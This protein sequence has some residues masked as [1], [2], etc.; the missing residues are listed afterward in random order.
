M[1][2]RVVLFVTATV[3]WGLLVYLTS[4]VTKL[5]SWVVY[6]D[7]VWAKMDAD[8]LKG[9]HMLFETLHAVKEFPFPWAVAFGGL[10][11]LGLLFR[12]LFRSNVPK[13]ASCIIG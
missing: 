11:F 2:A 9:E 12:E 4:L 13:S 5:A 8:G 6:N 1:M 7:P 3:G 10:V